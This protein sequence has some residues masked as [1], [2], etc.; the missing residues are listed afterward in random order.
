MM[1][2]YSAMQMEAAGSSAMLQAVHH[3]TW[4]HIT[5]NSNL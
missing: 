4:H 2:I 5:Q 3:T 1:T